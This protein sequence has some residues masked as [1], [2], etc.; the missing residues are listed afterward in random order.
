MTGGFPVNLIGTLGAVGPFSEPRAVRRSA[1]R[2]SPC[3]SRTTGP[4]ARGGVGCGVGCAAQ[5]EGLGWGGVGNGSGREA[6]PCEGQG[7]GHGPVACECAA[8]RALPLGQSV[9]EALHGR[10]H[11]CL[12]YTALHSHTSQHLTRHTA[13][14]HSTGRGSAWPAAAAA[15]AAQRH[16]PDSTQDWC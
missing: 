5:G 8:H 14:H 10:G 13:L 3:C 6:G 2:W 4:S 9:A 7:Q 11:P 12:R 16:W 15:A 1:V